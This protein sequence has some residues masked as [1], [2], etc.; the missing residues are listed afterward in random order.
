MNHRFFVKNLCRNSIFVRKDISTQ[1]SA[2]SK[3][4][5]ELT[6]SDL[7]CMSRIRILRFIEE[8]RNTNKLGI[9][10]SLPGSTK[11]NTFKKLNETKAKNSDHLVDDKILN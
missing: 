2:M 7:D 3:Y 4:F 11:S 5:Q 10:I 6:N 1:K 9:R 8:K